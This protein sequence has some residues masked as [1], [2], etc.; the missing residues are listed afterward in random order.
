MALARQL[1]DITDGTV[2][3]TTEAAW[4]EEITRRI[5]KLDA[6]E[7]ETTAADEF[8]ADLRRLPFEQRRP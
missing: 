7:A 3:P 8:F 5:E 1:L 6:G 2:E 4:E